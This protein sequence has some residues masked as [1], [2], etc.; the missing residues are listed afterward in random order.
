[1]NFDNNDFSAFE[2]DMKR[3][4]QDLCTK[5]QV[6]LK[7]MHISYGAVD[8]DM[9][10]TFE[11]NEEG[12]NTERVKFEM[13]CYRYGFAPDDYMRIFEYNGV[14][15]ELIGFDRGARK[16][17]CIV[18]EVDTGIQSKINDQFLHNILLGR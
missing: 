4:V 16:Y 7:K 17:N 1:M 12:L 15:Y 10:L 13:A 18:R 14:E 9:K 2:R 11:K 6:K 5:Y 3:A 8:F